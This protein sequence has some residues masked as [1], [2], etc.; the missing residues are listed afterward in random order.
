MEV[1]AKAERQK[2][3]GVALDVPTKKQG[4]GSKT[5]QNNKR[6]SDNSSSSSSTSSLPRFV[7]RAVAIRGFIWRPGCNHG[8][9]CSFD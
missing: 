5:T 3:H 4:R 7:L 2:K 8:V 1:R 6:R 9:F